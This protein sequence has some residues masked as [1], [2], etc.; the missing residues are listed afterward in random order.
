MM[1]FP[2][3][4]ALWMAYKWREAASPEGWAALIRK[5][6]ADPAYAHAASG[7]A[8]TAGPDSGWRY[9]FQ[10]LPV[11]EKL[12][13]AYKLDEIAGQGTAF[14]RSLRLMDWL[15]AHTYYSGMSVWSGYFNQW[16]EDS[17]QRL[18]FAFD[19]PFSHSL[20]CRHKAMIFA[21]C[22]MAVGIYA[23]PLGILPGH[24][25]THVWL[26]EER[27][28]IMLD[29]SLGSYIT[30]SEGRALNLIEIHDHHRKGEALRVARYSLNG[31]QDCRELYL[32]CFVLNSLQ[33]ITACDGSSRKGGLRNQ[34]L[35]SDV[36]LKD[37]N[38][39]AITSTELLAEPIAKETVSP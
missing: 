21:D 39:R 2:L 34:L 6:A 28:W 29:P 24:L 7:E 19:K 36:P 26:P 22:L 25:V 16:R 14:E 18:R 38:T 30:G 4:R 9:A 8:F 20:N 10:L 11:H 33:G 13:K 5:F 37:K 27:G 3:H 1:V 23:M 15:T 32:D 31:T 12:R 35:P 17:Y